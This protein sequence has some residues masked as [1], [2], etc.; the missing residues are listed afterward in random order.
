MKVF[1][2]LKKKTQKLKKN[3]IYTRQ[4]YDGPGN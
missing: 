4:L 3:K 1:E 2:F